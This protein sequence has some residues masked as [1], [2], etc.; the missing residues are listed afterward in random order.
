MTAATAFRSP[1]TV[2]AGCGSHD[3]VGEYA[4]RL[5]RHRAL[6]VT[7][8]YLVESGVAARCVDALR[9]SNVAAAVFDGVQPDPTVENVEAGVGA[10]LAFDADIVV[11]LGGGSVIDAA[12]MIAVRQANPAPLDRYQGYHQIPEPGLPLV[13]LPTTAGTG[14]EATGVAVI[15]D[16]GQNTKMMILDP[17]LVPTVAIIDPLLSS[18]MP[19]TLTVN[20]GVDTLTHGVEAYV[21]RLAGPLADIH[22]L[23]CIDLVARHLERAYSDGTD[24]V[25]REGMA[26][27]A[28]HGGLAFSNAS[29]GLVHGMSRPVGAVFHVAH[30][31]SN[32][33]LLETVTRF[34]L[35]ASPDR[36]AEVART[37]GFAARDADVETAAA[38]LLPG[39]T[40]WLARLSVPRLRDVVD[41]S[42]DEFERHLPKMAADALASGSPARNPRIATRGE[43]IALYQEAW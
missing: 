2:V 30:G 20:V 29:V 35:A 34:S 11:A 10:L 1:A 25:A 12:K 5:R 33:V 9:A 14:S 31:L 24:L 23:R 16:A 13:V 8:R 26:L 43:I 22:A 41:A 32:A 40:S 42:P 7:D 38:A 4:R 37:L 36:Y 39:L 19:P 3:E 15:T 18:T 27:A 28:Y 21:S 6:V 17:H